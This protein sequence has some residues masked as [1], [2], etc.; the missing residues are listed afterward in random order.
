MATYRGKVV[1]HGMRVFNFRQGLLEV[2]IGPSNVDHNK[3]GNIQLVINITR[4]V[5]AKNPSLWLLL[6]VHVSNM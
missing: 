6:F 1:T 3:E 2:K 4:L 5:H